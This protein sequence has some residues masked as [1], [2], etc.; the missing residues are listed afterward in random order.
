[1]PTDK[2][3]N[4]LQQDHLPSTLPARR[5]G[6][7]VRRGDKEF[8]EPKLP[9]TIQNLAPLQRAPLKSFRQRVPIVI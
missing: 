3:R 1:M 6:G 8:E 7:G 4:D 2:F 5:R 9:F